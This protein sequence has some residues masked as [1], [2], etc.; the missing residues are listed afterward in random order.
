MREMSQENGKKWKILSEK[1]RTLRRKA[2]FYVVWRERA[3]KKT[4]TA[5]DCKKSH[6]V[7]VF[8]VFEVV[9]G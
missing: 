7:K 8:F 3:T 9:N 5:R 4:F 1:E 2:I 6:C